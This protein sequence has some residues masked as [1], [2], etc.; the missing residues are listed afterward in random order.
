MLSKCLLM[1][2]LDNN[3]I[4]TTS[5]KHINKL[6]ASDIKSIFQ[7]GK[8]KSLQI[9]HEQI[10]TFPG[11]EWSRNLFKTLTQQS[12]HEE[13]VIHYFSLPSFHLLQSTVT[14]S[15]QVSWVYDSDVCISLKLLVATVIDQ[16]EKLQ[17]KVFH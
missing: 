14:C 6:R 8:R 11:P 12:I 3:Y 7:P 15:C 10:M 4:Q 16:P 5:S 2:A 1:Y 13:K 17:K 9:K